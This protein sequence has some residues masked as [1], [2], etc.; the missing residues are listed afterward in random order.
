VLSALTLLSIAFTVG[1]ALGCG[2][3]PPPL[4]AWA[5]ALGTAGVVIA[6]RARRRPIGLPSLALAGALGALGGARAPPA[7]PVELVDGRAWTVDARV[8]GLPER[9][10]GAM[11]LPLALEA[12][13]RGE[14]RRRA[15]ARILL[16]V[17]GEPLERLLPGDRVRFEA[18][19]RRPRGLVNQGAPDAALRA[20]ADG[21]V[22]TAHLHQAAALVRRAERAGGGVLRAAAAWRARMLDCVRGRLDGERRA[23]VASL[24][25]GDRGD[26]SPALDDAFRRAGVSHVLSVSGLHLAIAA[27]LFYAG[28]GWLLLRLPR[29][30]RGRPARR[31]AA[32]AALPATLAYTLVTGAQVAT[33]RSCVVAVVW[34]AG[35]AFDRRTSLVD[36]VALAALAILAVAPLE[37]LDPSF[38][39]SFAAALGTALLGSR[40]AV[41]SPRG[42][43]LGRVVAGA[44]RLC[45]AS[46]AAILA[47]LPI[48]AWHFSQ[49]APA[50]LLSNLVVVPVTELGIVPVGLAGCVL[51]SLGLRATSAVGGRLI[52]LAGVAAAA[53]AAFVRW[54]AG[55]APAFRVARP[56]V[57]ELG[58]W[59]AGLWALAAGGRRGRLAALAC[60]VVI[61]GSIG[62]RAAWRAG[63][64]RLTATFLDVGQG[65]A[66]VVELPHGRVMVIDG[67]GSFDPAFDPGAQVVAPF[68][69]RRGIR[70][71][72]LLILTHPHPDHANGLPF[73]VENFAVGEVW[74]NGAPTALPAALALRAAA[75]ARQVP[76]G[77]PRAVELGGARVLPLA[78]LGPDGRIAADA[79]LG[80]NDNS[81]VVA[82]QH[83]GRTLLFAGDVERAAEARLL[84]RAPG[85]LRADL[86]KAPHH[87]SRTS[88]TEELVAAVRPGAVVFSVGDHNRWGFPH[89]EVTARYRAAGARLWRTDRD[90]AVIA[91]VDSG[92]GLAID[93][94][95]SA[96]K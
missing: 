84:A 60:A 42:G 30:G 38:Q 46:A 16:I 55:W 24:V 62:A 44:G 8:A 5:V 66:C 48:G 41:P 7:P 22:A 37:L 83:A 58:A 73:L 86:L 15:D 61:G 77:P 4:V 18:V 33:V 63:S 56:S 17:D 88:S 21:V 75:A 81:L 85:L 34:L 74:E 89:V 39:L 10:A 68:L 79:A 94:T 6:A 90:G 13:Q 40:W 91:T 3:A 57:I 54:F 11:R 76:L 27:G 95:E 45:V 64:S 93:G 53:I 52:E 26:V 70:R 67:G 19:L 96:L 20:A 9:A 59:Y 43:V 14:T 35:V 69:W 82:V 2:L 78:P 29:V 72:D 49:V 47:T 71:I 92:G 80:E 32:A 1:V 36:A 23:L 28:V 87:G 50:G 51:D 65:D 25:L 31:W 12:V